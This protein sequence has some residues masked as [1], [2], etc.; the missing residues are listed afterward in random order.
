MA[1]GKPRKRR[2]G[3]GRKP[4]GEHSGVTARLPSSRCT[5]ETRRALDR[6]AKRNGRSRAQEIEVRLRQSLA[7]SDYEWQD[8]ATTEFCFLVME[9][10]RA[11]RLDAHT[12]WQNSEY[13]RRAFALGIVELLKRLPLTK[14]S[15]LKPPGF[16][17]EQYSSIV[18]QTVWNILETSLPP[19][20]RALGNYSFALGRMP[21]A[22]R[23]L[24]IEF[25]GGPD[26]PM[27]T[28]EWQGRPPPAMRIWHP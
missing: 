22:R 17:E 16:S 28:D 13:L 26:N 7:A 19:A 20:G 24:G 27:D 1:S 25:R 4:Q 11:M 10:A 15:P 14:P 3:G 2:P 6:A 9:L 12:T 5:P 23:V 21:H 8:A 18:V